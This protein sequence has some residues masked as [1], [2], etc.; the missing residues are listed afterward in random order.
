ML[1]PRDG[2]SGGFQQ[3]NHRCWRVT[4]GSSN[5]HLTA[6]ASIAEAAIGDH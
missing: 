2:E 4:V 5:Q 1:H 3:G 6:T